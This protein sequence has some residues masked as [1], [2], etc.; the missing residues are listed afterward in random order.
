MASGEAPSTKPGC[1]C[2][3]YACFG[4]A[5]QVYLNERTRRAGGRPSGSGQEPTHAPQRTP[6]SSKTRSHPPP[7]A[8]GSPSAQQRLKPH[9]LPQQ[10]E[11]GKAHLPRRRP[12]DRSTPRADNRRPHASSAAHPAAH[13]I[14]RLFSGAA[15]HLSNNR[16]RASTWQV[17]H[18]VE[19][20]GNAHSTVLFC[21]SRQKLD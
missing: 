19:N 17:K 4:S 13:G 15:N 10:F 11:I 5:R 20:V 6:T 2:R 1:S 7:S 18:V 12:R 8:T 21:L 3:S 16:H 9:A 14:R